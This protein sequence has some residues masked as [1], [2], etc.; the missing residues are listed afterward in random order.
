MSLTD[1]KNAITNIAMSVEGV[2]LIYDQIIL[3]TDEKQIKD[4]LVFDGSI[5]SI[6]FTEVGK[7][8]KTD[9]ESF[10][11]E[12]IERK[13][14]FVVYRGYKFEDNSESKHVKFIED[15]TK[16]FNKNIDLNNTVNSHSKLD[17]IN[18]QVA[19]F[20]SILCHLGFLEMTTFENNFNNP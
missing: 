13:F 3:F 4:R 15:L 6:G 7:D 17:M 5:N 18:N 20:G 1:I 9:G 2:G 12:Q 19:S 8:T 16:E 14:V 10:H 11:L